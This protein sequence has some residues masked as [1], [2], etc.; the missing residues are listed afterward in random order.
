MNIILAAITFS[1][2]FVATN[3][4]AQMTVCQRRFL[5]SVTVVL[6][7]MCCPMSVAQGPIADTSWE[8]CL[9]VPTR[10]CI[11]DEA[12]IRALSIEPAI[13][14]ATQLAN[15]AEAHATAGNV[16]AALRIAHSIPSDQLSRLTA[17]RSIAGAQA[18][19]G[20]AKEAKETFIQAHQL[21]YALTDQLLRAEALLSIAK[22]EAEA[23]MATEATS[24]FEESLKLAEVLEISASSECA[25]VPAPESRL[26]KLLMELAEQQARAGSISNSL[27]AARSIKYDIPIRARALLKIAEPGATRAAKRERYH[28]E[29]GFGGRACVTNAAGTLAELSR[30]P[31]PRGKWRIICGTAWYCR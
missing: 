14:G 26:A 21:A 8:I 5:Q 22:A 1:A 30:C 23:G 13:S 31:P 24:T 2:T 28:P 16:Q 17:L 19:L 20:L 6:A 3:A 4:R 18:N 29:G 10:A 25:L 12:L 11:L 27:R 9:K 7:L 15:I